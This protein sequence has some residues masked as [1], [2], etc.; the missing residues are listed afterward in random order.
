M[1]EW[2]PMSLR[3]ERDFQP[4]LGHLKT[5]VGVNFSLKMPCWVFL[6]T[7][8]C[9]IHIQ[10]Y[11]PHRLPH[12]RF[13][14]GIVYI[15]VCPPAVSFPDAALY[16]FACYRHQ[17]VIVWNEQRDRNVCCIT[18]MLTHVHVRPPARARPPRTT[19]KIKKTHTHTHTGLQ[20]AA[21]GRKCHRGTLF[22]G[23][24]FI[25]L[26]LWDNVG[27]KWPQPSSSTSSSSSPSTLSNSLSDPTKHTS[28]DSFSSLSPSLS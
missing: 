7:N 18:H 13:K 25:C 26:F 4:L 19:T 10:R 28:P 21:S 17:N 15:P 27:L 16:F 24:V 8:K 20:S 12:R 6:W 9:H 2:R 1:S 11:L 14:S 5:S 3:F 22:S 23:A